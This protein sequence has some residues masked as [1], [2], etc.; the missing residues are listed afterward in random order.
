MRPAEKKISRLAHRDAMRPKI[1]QPR[2]SA[3]RQSPID[4]IIIETVHKI[5][6]PDRLRE[7]ADCWYPKAE[8]KRV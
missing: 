7:I 6:S 4:R 1:S 5:K 8:E 3:A 2:M